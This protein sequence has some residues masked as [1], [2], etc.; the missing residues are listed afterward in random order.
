VRPSREPTIS[1]CRGV[2][3]GARVRI[4]V[5]SR[6]RRGVLAVRGY[7]VATVALRVLRVVTVASIFAFVLT[8]RTVAPIHATDDPAAD[9]STA[10]VEAT[11]VDPVEPAPSDPPPA[12]PVDPGL[13][14]SEDVP[15]PGDPVEPAPSEPPPADT[16][17]PEVPPSDPPIAEEPPSGDTVEPAPS[18][19][20]PADTVGTEVPPS[21]PPVEEEPLP[22]DPVAT[23]PPPA[24]PLP[25][26][27]PPVD[28]P[29]AE[30]VDAEVPPSDLPIE[31]V[32]LP[33]DTIEPAP[34][35]PPPADATLPID[36]DASPT[37]GDPVASH[38]YA[39]PEPAP[40]GPSA[41]QA[42]LPAPP[43]AE[44]PAQ[45]T[46]PVTP[47]AGTLANRLD[48]GSDV[49]TRSMGLDTMVAAGA[50]LAAGLVITNHAPG[51]VAVA[52]EFG[53]AGSGWAGALVFN[54]WLRRQLR[55]RRMSQRQLAALSGVDHS[56]ISRLLRQDRR[57]S[58]ITATKLAGALKQL[59]GEQAEPEAAAYFERIPEET[60]FPARRVELALRADEMLDDEQVRRL[61][62]I[63][64]DA[65]R[66]SQANAPPAS[67]RSR[68]APARAG[69]DAS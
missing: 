43:V 32:P 40:A 22:V 51:S 52:I 46:V 16:V 48:G 8:V 24:D 17:D 18:D 2:I 3:V 57:P 12:D 62:Y 66:K 44:D 9:P 14:P 26:D 4:R 42:P 36:P 31:E 19:P 49:P 29:P 34:S 13:P 15:L 7:D 55:E 58:L 56:T 50:G 27:P 11:P 6:S 61:M 20:P 30:T 47:I 69:R 68:A 21:D 35:D 65:R 63:Y 28:P 37:I 1:R 60:V 33:G 54:L 41:H 39:A 59:R 64:L 5:S 23:A 45:A 53:R 38:P 67:A 10:L 25:S